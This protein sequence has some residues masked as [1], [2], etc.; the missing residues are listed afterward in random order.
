MDLNTC[1]A[2]TQD[3]HTIAYY[4]HLIPVSIAVLLG[5]FVFFKSNFSLLSKVFFTFIMGFCLWLIGDV[6]IWTNS[7]YHLIT[8]LWAPLDYIN[9]LFYLCAAYFF[10]VLIR[11]GDIPDWQKNRQREER[12][13]EPAEDHGPEHGLPFGN[14]PSPLAIEHAAEEKPRA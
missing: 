7:D 3:Y 10:S 13:H 12:H 5:L 4:S 1:I 9:I 14:R 8:A 2:T 6:I 11:G